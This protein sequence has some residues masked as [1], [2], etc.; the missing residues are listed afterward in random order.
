MASK[1]PA[2]ELYIGGKWVKPVKGK[3][4][5]VICPFDE[6]VIGSIPLATKEDVNAAVEAAR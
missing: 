3:R 5:D 4:F 1:V 6:T 2:R